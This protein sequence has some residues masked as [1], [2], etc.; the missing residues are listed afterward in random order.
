M[1]AAAIAW[2]MSP[3]RKGRTGES[4][5]SIRKE[6]WIDGTVDHAWDALGDWGALHERL[7]PGFVTGVQLEGSDR[8]VTFFN[9]AVVRERLVDLDENARRVAWSIVDGPYMHHNGSAQVFGDADGVRFVWITDLL[10]DELVPRTEAM[11]EQGLRAIKA[12]LES[13]AAV[14][15]ARVR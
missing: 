7:A 10:P 3:V 14:S 15:R 8:L 9:G 12:K 2:M 5:A 6:I 11:M 13:A 1:C 4:M